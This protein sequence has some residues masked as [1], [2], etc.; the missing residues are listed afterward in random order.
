MKKLATLQLYIL[1]SYVLPV[2][3]FH[4][5]IGREL[6]QFLVLF[7]LNF[8]RVL[9]GFLSRFVDDGRSEF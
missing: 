1:R 5:K 9:S 4:E 6:P 7:V 2:N 8:P 3:R